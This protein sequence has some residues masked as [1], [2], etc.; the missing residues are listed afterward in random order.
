MR[1]QR[2]TVL[3]FWCCGFLSA[4]NV[5]PPASDPITIEVDV[6]RTAVGIIH[7]H[8]RIPTSSGTVDLAYPKWVPGQHSPKGPINEIIEM[9]FSSGGRRL[10]WKREEGDMYSFHLTVPEGTDSIEADLDFACSKFEE[11]FSV[12]AG[13]TDD[14]AAVDWNQLLL[15][16][17]GSRKD[18]VRFRAKLRFPENW[19]YATSLRT[20]HDSAGLVE[21]QTVPLI[22]LIDSPALVGEHFA[23]VPLGGKQPAEMDIAAENDAA[24]QMSAVQTSQFKRLVSESSNLFGGPHYDRYHFLVV[25]SDPLAGADTLE[26]F[27]ASENRLPEHFFRDD[28][29]F[30]TSAVLIPH[31]YVH[32]WN[33]KYRVPSG[34]DTA[35]Y[36]Q[37]IRGSLLWVY[38]G[39]T[40]YLANILTARSGFWTPEQYREALALDAAGVGAHRGRTWRSLEDTAV[41]APLLEYDAPAGWSSERRGADY[42]AESGLIWLEVDTLIRQKTTGRRSID[43]FCRLFMNHDASGGPSSSGYTFENIVDWLNQTAEFDWRRFLLN[44]LNATLPDAPLG[45]IEASGWKLVYTDVEPEILKQLHMAHKADL[46]W[47][48]WNALAPVDVRY[49]IG[50]FLSEDGAVIDADGAGPAFKAGIIPGMHIVAVNGRRF[51]PAVLHEAIAATVSGGGLEMRISTSNGREKIVTVDYRSGERYPHL[52]RDESKPDLLD[53]IIAPRAK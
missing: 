11:G 23:V 22:T 10:P 34:L 12:S 19:R 16:P 44:R 18:Q 37:P 36:Q 50:L 48:E 1:M 43:D 30:V 27:H 52:V 3:V 6:S 47:P 7:S 40:D 33:G 45:G 9:Q 46:L 35:N 13:C 25:L 5:P 4:I 49:S 15:Y 28:T 24:L 26:H 8:L 41:S 29:L 20:A 53:E 51:S 14:M 38:E 39:L 21:F 17:A 2:V 32:S 42:Y 31:E